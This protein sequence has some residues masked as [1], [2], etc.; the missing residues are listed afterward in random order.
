MIELG[1]DKIFRTHLLEALDMLHPSHEYA[2]GER[3]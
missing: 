3:H 2:P 1:V